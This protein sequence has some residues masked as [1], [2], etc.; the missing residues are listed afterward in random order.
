M[1]SRCFRKDYAE[2]DRPAVPVRTIVGLLPL[3]QINNLKDVTVMERW[4]E[5]PYW[6]HFFR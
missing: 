3:K 6:Q 5:N 2:V 1:P 4:L